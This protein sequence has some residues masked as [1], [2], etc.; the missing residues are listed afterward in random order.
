[1][2]TQLSTTPFSISKRLKSFT[3]AFN[4][5]KT[6]IRE[7]H[8]SWIHIAVTICVVI[9][10]FLLS[11]SFI[12][13]VAVVLCIGLVISFELINSAIENIADFV[14]PQKNETIRK[15][16]DLSAAAVLIAA[17]CSSIVGLIIFVPKIIIL[18]G[19]C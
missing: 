15:V 1:M 7:E 14:S 18:C 6:L 3:F 11:I 2:K 5:F 12:E 8:N 9:A 13:W 17:I 19:N 4:G 16:K 10:G